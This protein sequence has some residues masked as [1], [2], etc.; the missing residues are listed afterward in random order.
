MKTLVRIM[1]I[2]LATGVLASCSSL[3]AKLQPGDKIGEMQVVDFCDGQVLYEVC[4]SDQFD[5]GTC[6]IPASVKNLWISPG[7]AEDTQELIEAAW[8]DSQWEVSLDGHQI[9]LPAFGTFDFDKEDKKAR[10]WNVC[11]SNLSPGKHDMK[12]HFYLENSI[13]RGNHDYTLTFTA[14]AAEQP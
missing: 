10:T 3:A 12:V 8:K 13:E 11:L 7:W 5:T 2:G 4:N 1:L 6:V 14:L 9:D